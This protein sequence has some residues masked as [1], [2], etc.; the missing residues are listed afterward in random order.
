MRPLL[1]ILLVSVLSTAAL[2]K[3]H[4]ETVTYRLGDQTFKSYLA[5]D[6]AGSAK[7]PGVLIA[8]E[9]LGVN[10]YPKHRA[11]QLAELG[12]VALVADIFGD[13]K[14]ASG[15]DEART[16]T[17]PFYADRSLL[18][19]HMTAALEQLRANPHVDAAKIAAMGYCFGG[20]AALELARSGANLSGVIS[21]HGSLTTPNS[22]D[23]EA[24]QGQVLAFHGA[25]DPYVKP[26]DVTAFKNE[27]RDAG[28]KWQFVEFGG[29]VHGFTNPANG[30]DNSK[31]A[32]YNAQA[33]RRSWTELQQFL[34]EVFA[35]KTP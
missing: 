27:L 32:A 18:R 11:E 7:H 22:A 6:D 31:G 13:G 20:M 21:F 17:G 12:Y 19:K 15:P 34:S 16:L 29:A 2:A 23:M 1:L 5:Y 28:V 35:S 9:W 14:I 33:D 10:D 4:T 8:P 3:L 26:E 25:D 30:S 24:F